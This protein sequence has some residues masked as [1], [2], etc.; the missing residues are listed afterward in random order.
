MPINRQAVRRRDVNKAV[1]NFYF[2]HQPEVAQLVLDQA[3]NFEFNWAGKERGSIQ[4]ALLVGAAAEPFSVQLQKSNRPGEL[5]QDSTGHPLDPLLENDAHWI[6]IGSPI[7][8]VGI[9]DITDHCAK[10]RLQVVT[11]SP[12]GN[13]VAWI[14]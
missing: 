2:A 6:N 1:E 4:I 12:S 14:L 9:T 13:V 11:P 5:A 3:G 7:V 10:L 8:A